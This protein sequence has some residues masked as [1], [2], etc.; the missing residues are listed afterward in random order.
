MCGICSCTRPT[1]LQVAQLAAHK[2]LRRGL[3]RSTTRSNPSQPYGSL[4]RAPGLPAE[5]ACDS[6]LTGLTL[7][8]AVAGARAEVERTACSLFQSLLCGL[9]DITLRP[10]DLLPQDSLLELLVLD[11]G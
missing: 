11:L 6:G 2:W 1:D 9:G 10:F 4:S 7:Q 3:S 5:T 8:P